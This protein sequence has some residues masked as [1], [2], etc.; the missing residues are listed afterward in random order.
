MQDKL[1]GLEHRVAQLEDELTQLRQVVA[2]MDT[3]LQLGASISHERLGSRK[4]GTEKATKSEAILSWAGNAA[5]LPRIATVCFVMVLALALRTSTDNGLID[6][7]IGTLLG[8][9]YAAAL[10][11]NGWFLYRKDNLQAPVL[12]ASGAFLMF[13][14]V[15]ET[16]ALFKSLPPTSAYLVLMVTGGGMAYISHR[17][18]KAMPIIIGTLL[19]CLGGV[20]I[21]YPTPIFSYLTPLLLFANIL[22]FY[23]T[24]LK[25]CSWLRWFVL[26]VTVFMLQL[27]AFK[28]GIYLIKDM[29]P[30]EPLSLY[31]FFPVMIVFG[32]AFIASSYFGIVRSQ[33]RNSSFDYAVPTLSAFWIFW[34][35]HYVV[36]RSNGGMIGL[37]LVAVAAAIGHYWISFGLAKRQEKSAQGINTFA[38]AGSVWLVSGLALWGEDPVFTLPLVSF[39]AFGLSYMGYKWH[40]GAT[41]VTSYMLQAYVLL[42]MVWLL[43]DSPSG[44]HYMATILACGAVS[45]TALFHYYWLRRNPARENTLF[46]TRYDKKDLSGVLVLLCGLIAGFYQARSMLYELLHAIPGNQENTF[47]CAQSILINSAV[48][49]LMAFALRLK[50]RE[51]R[52]VAILVTVLGAGKVFMIDL[53]STSGIP[54]VLSVLSFGLVASIESIILTRWPKEPDTR[55]TE[56]ETGGSEE[57]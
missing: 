9:V 47:I 7:Q 15:V 6:Q 52:N 35:C 5:L 41:R 4:S 24:R 44:V 26:I 23:A 49:V 8:M 13:S 20:V 37:G 32:C 50:S 29:A 18:Q 19:M 53:F 45:L 38:L 42:A 54:L 30:P 48:I 14:V 10:M 46:F 25:R 36:A 17:F 40:S 22:G 56:T 2:D 39:T 43:H 27:W 1:L 55:R 3:R 51:L 21:D 31:W 57:A 28:L 12:T 33:D 11:V 16:Q 34:A